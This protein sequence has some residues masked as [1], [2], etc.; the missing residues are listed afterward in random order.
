L[1]FSEFINSSSRILEP[2]IL[3][4]FTFESSLSLSPSL[5]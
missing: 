1:L 5:K 2:L 4:L 3:V